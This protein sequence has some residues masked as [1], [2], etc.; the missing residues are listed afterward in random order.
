[1]KKS[2]AF[3]LIF[4]F[5]LGFAVVPV[6][7][8]SIAVH[9]ENTD[10]VIEAAL[11]TSGTL[12]IPVTEDVG[13]LNGTYA[14]TN[15]DSNPLMFVG[16]GYDGYWATGRSWFKF[17][18]THLPLELSV[19]KATMN[20]YI[21]S[22]WV[23][24]DEPVGVYHCSTDTWDSTVITWN[25]QP[26]I[27]GTPSDVIDSPAS[28]DMFQP[29]N[30]YAWEVT[31]DVRSSMDKGDMILSEVLK[32]TVEVG[33]QNAFWYPNRLTDYPFDA[34]YLEIEYTT[35]TTSGLSVDGITSGPLLDYI[36]NPNPELDWTFTDPDYQDFQKDYDIEVWNN[37]HYNGTL[38]WHASHESVWTIHNSY[39]VLGNWHPFG[40]AD[41]FRMQMK[42]PSSEILKSGI[43]DK[44]YFTSTN[45]AGLA[46][47][48][49]FEVSLTLV[50]SSTD[51]TTDF[52]ANLEGRTPTVV[53]SRDNYD[54]AVVN[55]IVELDLE[56][57]FFVNE[58]LNLIVE[59]RLTNNT[60]NKIPLARTE[61]GGPGS[62]A[63]SYGTGAYV[64][65]TAG[66]TGSR[67]YDLSIGYLTKTVYDAGSST[68]GF[69]FG[70]T[71]GEPGRF[72]IKYN[73]SYVY[74]T[75]YLD[76]MYF[77]VTSL[78]GEVTYE[79]LTISIVETPVLGQIDH[80]DMESNYGGQTPV[81]VL[82]ESMYTV[83]NLGYVLVIDFDNSYYYSNTHDLLIDFQWD[84]LVSGHELV[85]YTNWHTS[86]F[87]AWDLHWNTAYRYDNGTAGYN[88]LLDFVNSEVSVPLDGCITLVNATDY[89]WRVRTCDSTGVWGEWTTAD[90]KY[91]VLSS[92]PTFSDPIA[93]P[94][95]VEVNQEVTVSI[96]ATHSVGINQV[97]LELDGTNYS[98]SA[99]VDTFSY[100]WTPIAIETVDYTIFIQ[101]NANTWDS[102]SG[103]VN[104]TASSL[105]TGTPLDTTMILIIVGAAAVVVVIIVIIMKKKK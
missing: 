29:M 57:T 48:E 28:P 68:N 44:L 79:N 56:N 14:D 39:S 105:P 33:T 94:N 89:Y 26:T 66:V 51:L 99:S 78:S 45:D 100:M 19:Q 103:S 77:P 95:P 10:S 61:S 91:E 22:E 97:L 71:I 38:L 24:A 52:S 72:Q 82:D 59:I 25:N 34:T 42:Y 64:A 47:L 2:G 73:Q 67:T 65:T 85:R 75:G 69:P 102:V 23:T 88:L 92:L 54:L 18:L 41:E 27:S 50:P 21:G 37:T 30:W 98:M 5:L 80:V 49:N 8:A 36:N 12:K 70:C 96:N 43:I 53:L 58:Y 13:V 87:R 11:A 32:Q 90:F 40:S 60:G 81:V 6:G 9:P 86:S 20:V 74:R 1:M 104:V 84:S 7:P 62:T 4:L 83:R 55:G 93:V 16:T 35:P 31:S 101:S 63:Y 76:K 3:L 46:H 15:Q 17:D